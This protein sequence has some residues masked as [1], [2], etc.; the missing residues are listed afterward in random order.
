[1]AIANLLICRMITDKTLSSYI[2]NM[3]YVEN[4]VK[5]YLIFI[6]AHAV[7]RFLFKN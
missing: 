1:M 4:K 7:I 3:D 5:I 6:I 2:L